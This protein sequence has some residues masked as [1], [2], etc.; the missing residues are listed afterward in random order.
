MRADSGFNADQHR[1]IVSQSLFV[2]FLQL[3]RF[4]IEGTLEFSQLQTWCQGFLQSIGASAQKCGAQRKSDMARLPRD[5]F[6]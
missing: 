5:H 1:K 3:A 4:L 2:S 6:P